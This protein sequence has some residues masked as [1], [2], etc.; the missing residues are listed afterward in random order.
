MTAARKAETAKGK[1]AKRQALTALLKQVRAEANTAPDF[2]EQ[3][4]ALDYH[5]AAE[6]LGCTHEQAVAIHKHLLHQDD[7]ERKSRADFSA[8]YGWLGL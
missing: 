1:A 7:T 6:A 3:G 5:N 4:G 2:A 8:E